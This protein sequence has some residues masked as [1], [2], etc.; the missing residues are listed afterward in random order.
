MENSP[1]FAEANKRRRFGAPEGNK[2]NPMVGGLM[3]AL[4]AWLANATQADVDALLAD[5]KTPAIKKKFVERMMKEG[6]LKD[7]FEM[8]NQ[9]EG[10][11]TQ[12]TVNVDVP[13]FII[14][15]ESTGETTGNN[16]GQD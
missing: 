12:P 16:E 6:K 11:P 9:I 3:R 2:P 13:T 7:F 1:A 15:K 14:D 8:T 4:Y 10:M 5:P